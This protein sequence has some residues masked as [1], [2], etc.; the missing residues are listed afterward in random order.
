MVEVIGTYGFEVWFLALDQYLLE[1]RSGA[2][3]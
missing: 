1:G 3:T 2:T